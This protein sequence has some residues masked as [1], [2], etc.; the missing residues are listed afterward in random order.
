MA[1]A[2]MRMEKI[3]SVSALAFALQHDNR[4]RIPVN[5]DPEKTPENRSMWS[6]DDSLKRHHELL[7]EAAKNTKSG[8][9]RSNAVHAVELI[10]TASSDWEGDWDKYL[11]AANNWAANLFGGEKNCIH[12]S[13]HVD[14]RT[15]HSHIIFTPIKDGKLN[16]KAFIG[17]SRD[18]MI[19]LQTDF[20]EK[21]GRPH[22]LDRGTPAKITKA[23]N[24]ELTDR[25]SAVEKKEADVKAAMADLADAE[26]DLDAMARY[27]AIGLAVLREN[28]ATEPEKNKFWLR[29]DQKTQTAAK[30]AMQ[31]IRTEIKAEISPNKITKSL[32]AG[33]GR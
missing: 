16:A 28:G 32:T 11:R 21:V 24:K 19:A 12:A 26:K 7:K 6:T 20:W 1:F 3:K 33:H 14:E 31:E 5:A 15:K 18:R 25:E 17:G 23:K 13:F 4:D 30:E 9:I 29:Y 10:F 8:K 22:G 27:K 2:I